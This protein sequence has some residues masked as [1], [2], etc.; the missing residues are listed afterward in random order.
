MA[1]KNIGA[2]LSIKDGGFNAGIKKAISGTNDFKK[3]TL[4]ATGSIKNMGI[5]A[6]NACG[7][8][9]LLTKNI[10]GLAGAY[11]GISSVKNLVSSAFENA[12]SMES[13]RG[14]LNAV[15]KDSKKA[16]ETMAWAVDFANKTPF[17]TDSI[18][19][20]T[21]R[22]SAY[23]VEAQ[24][25][26]PSI[27]NMAG[28]MNKDIMQAVEAVADAQTG[29][30]ERLKEFGITK[31]MIIDQGT[32]T[33]KGKQL[34]NNKGQIVDQV[35]FN[36]ALFELMDDRFKGGMEIQANSF[37]GLWSTVKGTFA[38][39]IAQMAGISAT[40]E[41]TIGGPFDRIKN[42]IK[43]VADKFTE[44][45]T[46]GSIQRA[47]E[48]IVV[49]MGKAE[50][51]IKFVSDKATDVYN[52]FRD[53]WSQ[54]KPIVDG[55]TKAIIIYNG[56][57]LVTTGWT[58]MCAFWQG[59]WTGSIN[60][61]RAAQS[62]ALGVEIAWS[63][64][65]GKDIMQTAI[66]T[67]MYAWDA[68]IK[69]GH[70]V[71]TWAQVTATGALT[72]A[73]WLLNAAFYASPI[74]WVVLGIGLLVGGIVL[75]WNKCEPF[76]NFFLGMWDSFKAK[77]D[78]FGGGFKGFVNILISGVNSLI[79]GYVGGING[80]INGVN[81]VSGA[82][83]IPAIPN[84]PVPQIPMLA[85]GGSIRQPGTVLVGEKG[86]ELLTLNKGAKV[87]PLDKAEG[88]KIAQFGD[89]KIYCYGSTSDEVID[90]IVP[91]LKLAIENL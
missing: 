37:K 26:M 21:V 65:R 20:A 50:N 82:I 11:I 3:N 42:I 80:L 27:G 16:G 13:Y 34:V 7:G 12:S 31:Q 63:I 66:L 45:S 69:G 22:L 89:I 79:R 28:V 25:V 53:N 47:S 19:E 41:V 32:K 51:G 23:G 68:I 4:S 9:G 36:K 55:I 46:D 54:I 72:G 39:S 29:E 49:W 81:A 64:W 57:L 24:K 91:K 87:T 43:G 75:L 62:G 5:G 15:M 85:K 78:D 18:V 84:L 48:T 6:K 33:M 76:R 52:V 2:T 58:K 44:W 60:L 17:E 59:I 56:T 35:N 77:L 73:Q 8:I 14:T 70:A 71:A 61:W 88:K 38:T 90:E 74:G 67:G 40:G 30:L 86:P 10:L 83:G 1:K